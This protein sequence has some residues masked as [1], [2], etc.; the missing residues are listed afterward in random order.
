MGDKAEKKY[1][2][3]AGGAWDDVNLARAMSE[4]EEKGFQVTKVPGPLLL[5]TTGGKGA[6]PMWMPF[7]V[8]SGFAPTK[9]L[10]E[11]AYL[12]ANPIEGPPD[13]DLD[14]AAGESPKW[15]SHSLRRG[16]DTVARRFRMVTGVTEDM[17][18]IFFGWKEKILLR[19][20]QVHYAAMSI[21]ERMA[22]A[23]ITGML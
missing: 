9:A 7:Q 10:L 16:A 20:M 19:A 6:V 11:S 23:K 17:I 15:T 8:S 21:R 3:I 2:N 22:N 18:D 5:T 13:P 14:V 1:I 12:R 4:F